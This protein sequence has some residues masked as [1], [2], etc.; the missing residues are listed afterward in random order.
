MLWCC[1]P[2]SASFS[3]KTATFVEYI[4]HYKTLEQKSSCFIFCRYR[5]LF[6][7][8]SIVLGVLPSRWLHKYSWL[9]NNSR[10]LVMKQK[11]TVIPWIRDNLCVLKDSRGNWADRWAARAPIPKLTF[12]CSS[13]LPSYVHPRPH[14]HTATSYSHTHPHVLL[15]VSAAPHG[16]PPLPPCKLPARRLVKPKVFVVLH[17]VYK[18]DVDLCSVLC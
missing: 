6:P 16:P 17:L 8:S 2:P 14:I 18:T 10:L 4:A 9:L 7:W 1:C 11:K 12:P 5:L 3:C 13:L 15:Q